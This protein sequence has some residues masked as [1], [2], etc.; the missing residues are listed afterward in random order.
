MNMYMK[1]K[2]GSVHEKK[3]FK[4]R[5]MSEQVYEILKNIYLF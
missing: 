5:I 3:N 1:L 4:K 2:Y